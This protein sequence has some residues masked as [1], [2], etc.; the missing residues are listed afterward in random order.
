[1]LEVVRSLKDVIDLATEPRKDQNGLDYQSAVNFAEKAIA[2][3][4]GKAKGIESYHKV[5]IRHYLLNISDVL[6]DWAV[7]NKSE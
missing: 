2:L 4:E 1:M 5:R 7:T 6:I 3:K